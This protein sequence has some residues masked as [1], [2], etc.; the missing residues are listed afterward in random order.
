MGDR[1]Q[2]VPVGVGLDDRNVLGPGGKLT[3][4]RIVGTDGI[5]IDNGL[6]LA[7]HR[8][9]SMYPPEIKILEI[10]AEIRVRR[11]RAHRNSVRGIRVIAAEGHKGVS[12]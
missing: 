6:G 4:Q 11:Y 3:G 8:L 7:V 9:L 5:E 12:L 2:S 1:D 10:K